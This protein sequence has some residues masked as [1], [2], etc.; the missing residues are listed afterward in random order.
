MLKLY[1]TLCTILVSI[2]IGLVIWSEVGPEASA[3]QEGRKHSNGLT[4][5]NA[6]SPEFQLN[7]DTQLRLEPQR[8]SNQ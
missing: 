6:A 8:D 3:T 4:S 5:T 7:L 2:Y 1:A